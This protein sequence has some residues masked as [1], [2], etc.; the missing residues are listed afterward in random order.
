MV[1]ISKAHVI[2][3]AA[4]A[5]AAAIALSPPAGWES[6]AL[7]AALVIGVIALWATAIVPE[8]LTALLFFAIAMLGAIAPADVVFSGFY[9]TAFWL[10]FSGLILGVGINNT[11]LGARIADRMAGLFGSGYAGMTA[12]VVAVALTLGFLMPSSMGR[13]ALLIPIISAYA[14]RMGYAP[15]SRG[16]SG[17]ILSAGFV[18]FNLCVGILPATVPNMALMGAVETLYGFTPLYGEWLMLHFPVTSLLKAV[19]VVGVTVWFFREP[20]NPAESTREAKPWTAAERR[21]AVLLALA[22]A[23]W[24][25]DFL[26]HISPAWIGLAA[27][28]VGL[29]PGVGVMPAQDLKKVNFPTAIYV[30]GV[31]GLGALVAHSGL[32]GWLA[33]EAVGVAPLDPEAPFLSFMTVALSSSAVGVATTLPGV[34]IVMAPL[35][36]DLAAA[37]GFS[38]EATIMMMAVGFTVFVLPYQAPPLIMAMHLGQVSAMDGVRFVLAVAAVTVVAL[39]PVN[40]L[41]WRLIGFI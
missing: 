6:F 26:H 14:A 41:W 1:Q 25:T 23:G 40:F 15:G 5:G 33:R 31:L 32:G 17:L 2:A 8:H 20:S 13:V 21:L 28:C 19:L 27:A 3:I 9:S 37:A 24:T 12:G 18:S 36:T 10:V 16:H 38:L 30:A 22:L 39:L 35:A 34:P 29:L 4:L 7:P 11:G